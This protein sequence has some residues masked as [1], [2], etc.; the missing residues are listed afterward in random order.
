MLWTAHRYLLASIITMAR[1]LLSVALLS[2]AQ[3]VLAHDAQPGPYLES[4]KLVD[5]ARLNM[6]AREHLLTDGRISCGVENAAV[7]KEW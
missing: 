5:R 4:D 7:R 3:R 1:F 6:C 2:V